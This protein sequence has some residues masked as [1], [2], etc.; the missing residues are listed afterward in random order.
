MAKKL[1]KVFALLM[2]VSMAMSL[3]SIS[4]FAEE[5]DE[6]DIVVKVGETAEIHGYTENAEGA[7]DDDTWTVENEETAKVEVTDEGVFVTGVSAGPTVITHTYYVQEESQPEQ[8]VVENV[9]TDQTPTD[10]EEPTDTEGTL[11]EEVLTLSDPL[12][13]LEEESWTVQ[14]TEDE[15][16]PEIPEETCTVNYQKMSDG[17]TYEGQFNEEAGRFEITVTIGEDADGDLVLDLSDVILTIINQYAVENGYDSYPVMPGDSNPIHLTI[18]NH[19]GHTYQYQDGSF[20]LSTAKASDF[21]EQTLFLGYDGQRIPASF[22]SAIQIS[23]RSIYSELFGRSGSAN[24]TIEDVFGIYDKLAEKGYTGDQAL[25]D[26]MLAYFN[27]FY[28]TSYASFAELAAAKP[29][30]GD[31]LATTGSNGIFEE[32]SWETLDALKQEHPEMVPYLHITDETEEGCDVQFR[33]PEQDLAAFAYNIFYQDFFSVGFGSETADMN[34]NRNTK[35]TRTR[36][37]GDYMEGTDLWKATDAY[38]ASLTEK[39]LTNA[40]DSAMDLDLILCLDGPGVGNGYMN[41]D[42]SFYMALELEQTDTTYTVRHEYYTNDSLTGSVTTDLA[43]N[44][45]TE[46]VEGTVDQEITSASAVHLTTYD[47]NDYTFTSVTPA[48]KLVLVQD[49]ASNVI[50]LRYDRTTGGGGGGTTEPD[51]DDDD[52]DDRPSNPDTD[53]P[54]EDTP[55]TDLPD[56]P[57]DTPSTDIPDEDTPTTDIPEEDTPMAEVPKTGDLSALWLALTGLSGSGLA[58]VTVLGRK[59]RDEE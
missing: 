25:T 28:G 32:V 39:E 24:V 40:D 49:E 38:L 57:G 47:G 34:P 3:M 2:T 44:V 27:D 48:D 55:T 33:W 8:P 22:S 51:D 14:V 53:I 54:D 15:D 17:I 30:L 12:Y 35:F 16:A 11:P 50:V 9:I 5:T 10:V 45:I 20:V 21:G 58:A 18:V 13:T 36:G 4:A 42:F 52:D 43:G 46:G 23:H 19:S 29:E 7:P 26:Y 1:Q 41:Y 59:K 37:I 56:V 6:A 31:T